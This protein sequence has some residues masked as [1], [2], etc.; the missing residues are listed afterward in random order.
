MGLRNPFPLFMLMVLFSPLAIDTFLPAVPM[1]ADSFAVPINWMQQCLPMFMLA[2]GAGQLLAGPL[3][4]RYG[5]RP[6]ALLG[7]STYVL[8]SLMAALAADFSVLMLARLG[9]GFSACALSVAAFAGVRDTFGAERAKPMFS[10]LNGVICIV[11]ALAP[12]LG[13]W[14]TKNW[15]WQSNFWFMIAYATVV[16]MVMLFVLKET[17]PATTKSEAKLIAI[18][19]YWPIVSVLEFRFY[20]GLVMLGMAMSVGFVTQAPARMMVELKLDGTQ[21]ALWFGANALINVAAAFVAPKVITHLGQGNGLRFGVGLMAISGIS[22]FVF[23][24]VMTPLAFMVPVFTASVGFCF[25]I[26]TCSGSALAPFGDRA[27]TAAAL[28]G[29]FQ[30]TGSAIIVGVLAMTGLSTVMQLSILMILP[31]VWFVVARKPAVEASR[32]HS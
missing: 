20:T 1:M 9:Q 19:A 29:L 2:Y 11:P 24:G 27:G 14:L 23:S 28:L 25:V 4:D 7:A 22:E 21:F 18:R 17:R 26:A 16:G 15:G 31:L 6:V 5:R 8:T 12:L 32:V 3:A 13:E 10:Y 30:M